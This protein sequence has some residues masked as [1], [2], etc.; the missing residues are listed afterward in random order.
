MS[1][2]A[3]L[4]NDTWT[5]FYHCFS[6]GKATAECTAKVSTKLFIILEVILNLNH[7]WKMHVI[8][9][10]APSE[11]LLKFP[12]LR[13]LMFLSFFS[14]SE[15]GAGWC[16]LQQQFSG[17][18]HAVVSE[19]SGKSASRVPVLFSS[20]EAKMVLMVLSET[21]LRICP[22]A[23][24]AML[25]Y[26]IFRPPDKGVYGAYVLLQVSG[27]LNWQNWGEVGRKGKETSAHSFLW[28]QGIHT[29]C[30]GLI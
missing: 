8:L 20:P 21:Q 30:I 23:G 13:I 22:T 17:V 11:E 29:V 19:K 25:V 9:Y 28:P 5:Q 27:K 3:G 15:R 4:L 7:I 26:N 24:F 2:Q 14:T 1:T 10:A 6:K 12:S 18:M 16:K